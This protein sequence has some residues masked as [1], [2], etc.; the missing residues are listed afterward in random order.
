MDL[1]PLCSQIKAEM[2]ERCGSDIDNNT[3]HATACGEYLAERLK[4]R[5]LLFS[6]DICKYRNEYCDMIKKLVNRNPVIDDTNAFIFDVSKHLVDIVNCWISC[7]VDFGFSSTNINKALLHAKN[8]LLK[9]THNEV[10]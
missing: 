5:L 6:P 10:L 4:A 9:F 1:S 3:S 2:I 8:S 7:M